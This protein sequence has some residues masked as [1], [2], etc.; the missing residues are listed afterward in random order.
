MIA[1]DEEGRTYYELDSD[2]ASVERLTQ[3]LENVKYETM[4]IY[5]NQIII[6]GAA[7]CGLLVTVP[8]A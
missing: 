4:P 5:D 6:S 1:T 2:L 3:M 7:K 8:G